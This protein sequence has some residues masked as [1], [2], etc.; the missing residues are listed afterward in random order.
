MANIRPDKM[1][2]SFEDSICATQE[3]LH[4]AVALINRC[5]ELADQCHPWDPELAKT[6]YDHA[7]ML[8]QQAEDTDALLR[9]LM[10]R[11]QQIQAF[12]DTE[13]LHL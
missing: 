5:C 12:F 2:Q 4:A 6:L 3:Q 9:T 1:R 7:E 8:K 10:E 11:Y 13:P